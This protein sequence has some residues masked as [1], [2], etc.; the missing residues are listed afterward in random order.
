MVERS[1][2]GARRGRGPRALAAMLPRVAGAARRR[3]GFSEAKVVTDWA[4][5]IGAELARS[6]MPE[7]LTFP[8]GPESGGTLRIRAA[9]PLALELQHLE[10]L[11]IERINRYFGYR[12]VSRL[13]FVQAAA[14]PGRV[15]A[16]EKPQ[17]RLTDD[18]AA[19]LTDTVAKI[20]DKSLKEALERLGKSVLTA[21]RR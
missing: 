14:L 1:D 10:P 7:R 20:E 5:I 11:V 8:Q 9:G 19:R 17:P 2:S 15:P 6:T 16:K 12:A 18:E 3:R 13:A 4:E 21:G